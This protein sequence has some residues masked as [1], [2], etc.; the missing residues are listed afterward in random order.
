MKS[1][2]I[3]LF[4]LSLILSGNA[5]AGEIANGKVEEV[6]NI[7]GNEK[8]FGIKLSAGSSGVCA[9]GFMYIKASSFGDDI[10]SYKQA[11]SLATTALVADKRIRVHNYTGDSCHGATFIGLYKN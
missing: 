10:D 7:V 9:G 4:S 5:V 1:I 6:T 11:F 8:Q 2:L 3:N